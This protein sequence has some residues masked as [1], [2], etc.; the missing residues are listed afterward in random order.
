[1]LKIMRKPD[2]YDGRT[3]HGQ[4]ATDGAITLRE[5]VASAIELIKTLPIDGCIT[6]S[7]LLPGFDPEGWGTT[8]DVDVFVFGEDELVHAIDLACYALQMRPG[9]TTAS[10]S[11]PTSST[12]RAWC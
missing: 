5:K 11:P 4:F 2:R 12:A 3:M 8:P 7:C 6:G 9:S 1:M 10:A